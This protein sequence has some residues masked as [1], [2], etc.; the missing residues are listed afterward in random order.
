M[1]YAVSVVCQHDTFLSKIL[2][3]CWSQSTYTSSKNSLIK[4]VVKEMES[5]K[6]ENALFCIRKVVIVI[7]NL[8]YLFTDCC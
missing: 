8:K 6:L 5:Y 1:P 2:P 7:V 4:D 3:V